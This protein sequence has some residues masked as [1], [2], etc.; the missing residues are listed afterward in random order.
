MQFEEFFVRNRGEV[1]MTTLETLRVVLSDG[2][3]HAT[4]ELVKKV[5]HRFS[6]TMHVAKQKGDH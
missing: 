2:D 5:G 1:F 3:W 4:E 6:A